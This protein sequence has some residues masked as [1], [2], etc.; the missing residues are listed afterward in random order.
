M[1]FYGFLHFVVVKCSHI[2]EE[3]TASTFKVTE[4]V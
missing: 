2:L 4:L 3:G 1:V